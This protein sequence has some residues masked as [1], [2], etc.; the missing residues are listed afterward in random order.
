MNFLAMRIATEAGL[1]FNTIKLGIIIKLFACIYWV[2]GVASQF[3][4]M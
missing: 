1:A 4:D 3:C 2:I